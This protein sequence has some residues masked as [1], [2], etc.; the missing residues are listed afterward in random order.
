L[1]IEGTILGIIGVVFSIMMVPLTIAASQFG[2]RLIR[3]FLR[4]IGTQIT[5]GIFT[6]TFIFCMLVLLQLRGI[7]DRQLPQ[8]SATIG[9]LLGVV[10]FA[11]LIFFI[12]H[13]A[14]SLQVS[15]LVTKVSKELHTAID[16]DLPDHIDGVQ[17]A[18]SFEDELDNFVP[19]PAKAKKVINATASGYVQFR[20]DEG[21]LH[22][23]QKH[24]MVLQ[25]VKEPGDFVVQNT[26]LAIAWLDAVAPAEMDTAINA[27]F[28][29]GVQRTLVQ[30]V[31]FGINELVEVAIRALS[32]AI[33]DPFTA[34]T[35]LD[36]LGSAL[37]KIETR[38]LPKA[39][40]FDNGGH[41]RLIRK[42]PTFNDFSDAAFN[43]IREY[44][45]GSKAVTKRLMDTI[46]IVA[47][48]AHIVEQQE[49]LLR[50]AALV[51]RGCHIGLP[52]EADRQP[53]IASYQ[54]LISTIG[55]SKDKKKTF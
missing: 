28:V 6:S 23:A 49:S 32:P 22:F 35:C 5:L 31:L 39:K 30:D 36:W 52:E 50:H 9:L 34:M 55:K 45:R 53:I 1:T 13:V 29:L 11:A 10:S 7:P 42:P 2:P 48:S 33:N 19:D 4:D 12:N 18:P 38:T 3:N 51:E 43:Q 14:V 47:Q 40:L 25:L 17:T 46:T 16:R 54:K 21:L 41:L 27:A 44:G 37:C 24:H 15:V 26:P 20:D 8:I